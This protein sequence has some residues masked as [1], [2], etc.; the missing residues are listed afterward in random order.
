[1]CRGPHAAGR[2]I[3]RAAERT[4]EQRVKKVSR[5][6]V[7]G[8]TDRERT[9]NTEEIRRIGATIGDTNDEIPLAI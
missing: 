1:M 3:R 9:K 2:L 7:V 6:T 8:E 4:G 5:T